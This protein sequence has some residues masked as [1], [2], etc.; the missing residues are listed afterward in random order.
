MKEYILIYLIFRRFKT[1]LR[2]ALKNINIVSHLK[3][4][5]L[6]PVDLRRFSSKFRP[7]ADSYDTT[8]LLPT[9]EVCFS[10]ENNTLI[11]IQERR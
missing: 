6:T 7:H 11:K 5:D 1:D 3:N 4:S 10:I 2:T 8:K 9:R